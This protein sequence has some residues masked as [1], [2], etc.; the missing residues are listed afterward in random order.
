MAQGA[1]LSETTPPKCHCDE[2]SEEAIPTSATGDC[3]V[4]H[5]PRSDK[6]D[7]MRSALKN[8]YNVKPP[9]ICA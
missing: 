5:A 7:V 9:L 8:T 6:I 4:A 2:R 1:T 3:F